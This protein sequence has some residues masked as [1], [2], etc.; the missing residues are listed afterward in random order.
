M[1]SNNLMLSKIRLVFHSIGLSCLGGAICLQI[2]VFVT[3][4]QQGYFRAIETNASILYAEIALTGFT[5]AYFLY[6]YQ[7][8]IRAYLKK[9]MT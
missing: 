6:V 4:L 5:A 1:G 8:E 7:R 2:I 9:M 3:I